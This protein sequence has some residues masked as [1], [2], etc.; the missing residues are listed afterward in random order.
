MKTSPALTNPYK[1]SLSSNDVYKLLKLKGFTN[2]SAIEISNAHEEGRN[3]S[4]LF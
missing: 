3:F 4:F 1:S 2:F